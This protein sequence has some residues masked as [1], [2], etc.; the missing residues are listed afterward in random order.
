MSANRSEGGLDMRGKLWPGGRR[1]IGGLLAG[2]ALAVVGLAYLCS[3]AIAQTTPQPLRTDIQ[4]RRVLST[5]AASGGPATRIAK[6]PRSNTLYY[7]KLAGG[8]HRFDPVAQTSTLIHSTAAHGLR[9]A[10]GFAIGRD[11][12]MYLVGN[13]DVPGI[14]TQATIVKG[15]LRPNGTR[16][17]SV[18]ARSAPYPKSR[19]AYD[20]RMNGLVVDPRGEFLYVNSGSRTDHG[21]VQSVGALYPGVREVGLTAIILRL[22]TAGTNIFL[23]NN[24]GWLRNNGYL[25]AE[26][27]RNTYDMAFAPNG[28]LFG[29]D[30][31]PDRDMPDEL[32]WL[33]EGRHYG[34]PWRIGGL[35]NPQ[36]FRDYDP[37]TDPLLDPAFNAVRLGYYRND[38]TFPPRPGRPL[39]EPIEN[40]GPHADS[41]RD[42]ATGAILDASAQGRTIASF[43]AHRSPLGIVFDT[44]RVL[45]P[46][47]R[48]D[49]FM[50]SWTRGDPSGD[51]VRGPFRDPSQDL[52][53]LDLSKAGD[54]YRMRA[55]RIVRSFNNPI[56]AE[57]VGNRIYVLDYG[58]AGNIWEVTLPRG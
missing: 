9:N 35:D 16:A 49:G 33:R 32:N 3:D 23:S 52:L 11:G 54:T 7:L 34:F 22:P 58:G 13:A 46:A 37:A 6:D 14:R 18:L 40:A 50:L 39:V 20:H 53:H 12:T 27:T 10:Q 4:V 15:T 55:T 8:I 19:T 26:G 36:Q 24:R 2:A 31:G 45:I 5:N 28:D 43:T 38:P 30:N 57:I 17:W 42:P 48:G 21:E 56:D 51:G 1:G 44:A 29:P 41:F 25:F 47:F